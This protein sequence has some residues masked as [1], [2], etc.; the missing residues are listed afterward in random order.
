MKIASI[1]WLIFGLDAAENRIDFLIDF[2]IDFC[3]SWG[4]FGGPF[5]SIFRSFSLPD[6]SWTPIFF[7]N[8]DIHEIIK[9]PIENQRFGEGQRA[10][11]PGQALGGMRKS[12]P[13]PAPARGRG[14]VFLI[15]VIQTVACRITAIQD[16]AC[17]I[18][19]ASPL[20]LGITSFSSVS[21]THMTLPT[22]A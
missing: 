11:I 10:E 8:V 22:K 21:Y 12:W 1:F 16:A 13:D 7:K 6:R 2:L 17:R 3:S 19:A 4:R 18:T 5:G 9:N 14:G 20:A 15:I